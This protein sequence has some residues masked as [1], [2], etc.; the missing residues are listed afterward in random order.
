MASPTPPLTLALARHRSG[1][2]HA[3]Q[4]L[5]QQVLAADPNQVDAL[6]L[7]GFLLHQQGQSAQ[8]RGLIERAIALAPGVALYHA[9]LGLVLQALGL[10]DAARQHFLR[11]A[12]LD[13]Q[14][15]DAFN[16]LGALL[17][18]AGQPAQAVAWFQQ[19]L[20]RQADLASAHANLGHAWVALGRH[21]LARDCF[22][23]VCRL[24]PGQ[25][26]AHNNLACALAALGQPEQALVCLRQALAL[27]PD[28][29]VA[30]SNLAGNLTRAGRAAEAL[31]WARQAV[32]ADPGLDAAW[33]HLGQALQHSGAV[34]EAGQAFERCIHL[35]G[36]DASHHLNQALC[37]LLQADYARGWAAYESRLVM[38]DYR[39]LTA[40]PRCPVWQGQA[41]AGRS[42][43]VM[44]EQGLGDTLQFVRFLPAL[45]AAG[46][47]VVLQCQAPLLRLLQGLPGAAQVIGVDDDVPDTDFAVS[48]MSLPHRLKTTLAS[49]PARLPYLQPPLAEV[50]Q[51]RRALADLQ[52]GLRIG[53]AW[54]GNPEHPADAYR[55]LPLATLDAL[56]DLPGLHFVSLQRE[57][58]IEPAGRL[59]ARLVD[60]TAGLRDM[61]DL[62]GLI[63]NLDLV[64]SVDTSVCH[65]AGAMARPVWVL[66]HA[67]PDFRWLMDRE[68]SPWYPTA[69]LFR[70]RRLGDWT[71][72]MARLVQALVGLTPPGAAPGP[73]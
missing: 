61:A 17:H 62:A 59:A 16:H 4:A 55:S 35:N 10:M 53:L 32:A 11:A 52:D 44:A 22:E 68:D 60:R 66:L 13:P 24:Q 37:L 67:G 26:D 29:A 48:L 28:F 63:A 49:V 38:P 7:A 64:I 57:R 31:D 25:A 69:R 15:P 65:L 21:D 12:D 1:D 27:Q 71:E 2:L 36:A 3:A 42:L 73:A 54:R 41:L 14:S 5:Y 40:A 8:G 58:P 20:S 33:K 34:A 6:H 56:A 46:A 50:L 43:R 51:W 23:T 47:R 30:M 70:Q 9:N 72:V 39:P 19:A 18:A 45:Q